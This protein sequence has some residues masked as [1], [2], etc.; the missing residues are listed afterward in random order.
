[1]KGR[2]KVR[3]PF[4]ILL[5]ILS[6]PVFAQPTWTLDPFG[7][8]KKPEKYEEKKLGSEKTA[9]K[10]FTTF[11]RLVQN[12]VTHYNFYF[13][14]N[15]KLNAVL[16]RAK[17]AQ[18]DDF[19]QLITFY[20]YSLDNTASQAVELDS[21][22]Y[23]ST[24]GILLH[25]LRSDWVDNMYL[26]IGKAYYFRKQFDSAALTF[27]FINYNLFPR[28]KNEDDNR[29]VGGNN[30]D[31]GSNVLSIANR[32]KRNVVQR[33]LTLPPSRNDAL[34]WLARTF[35]E[36]EQFGDAAGMINILQSDPNLPKRL[37]ND[38]DEVTAYWFFKQKTYDS[39][40]VYLERG[41]SNADNKTDKARWQYLLGQLFE[42]SGQYDKA[43]DYYSKAAKHTVDPVMDIY[44]HL[45]DA[46]MMRNA[47]NDKELDNSIS[48]LLK[49]AKKDKYESYR[50]II[51]HSAGMLS[52]KKPDT[53]S[54]ITLF[55]KSLKYNENNAAF[56]NKAHLELGKIAYNQRQYKSAA[57]HYDSLDLAEPALAFDS[58]SIA[59]RKSTL[60][61]IAQELAVI[62]KQ[63][64]VQMIAAMPGPER[65]A[66]IRKLAKK[67]RKESG[68]KEDSDFEGNTLITAFDNKKTDEPADLFQSSSKGE[69]YFYNAGMKSKGFNEFKA[70]WGKREN[71]DNW[72]R[73]SAMDPGKNLNS[74]VDDPLAPD[75]KTEDAAT[76][77]PVAYSY[78][79][80]MAD[81]PL[82]PEQLDSSNAMIADAL[83]KLA[84]LFEYEL[85]DYLEAVYTYDIYLQRFPDRLKDG[86]IY[87]GLYHCYT[88][89]GDNNKA[90]YYKNLLDTKFANSSYAN[91]I[92]NP[93]V[94]QPEKNNPV[95]AARYEAIYNKF[96]EGDFA[97]A[98]EEKRVADSIHGNHYWTPQLLYIEAVHYIKE[99]QDSLAIAV[100]TNIITLY[101]ESS[102]KPKAETMIE[103]LKRR[104]EIEAYLTNLEVTRL[105]EDDKIIF[106][107]DKA[108]QT[109]TPVVKAPTVKKM[110]PVRTL[111]APKD[112]AVQL[113]PS[114]VMGVY[115]WQASKP[116]HVIMVLDRVDGVYINEAKNA[117]TRYNREKYFSKVVINKDAIDAQRSL[118]V[119]TSF[120][121][122][123]EA[124]AYFDKVK[125]AAPQEVSWLQ[126]SKYSFLVISEENLQLLKTN[127]DINT[128][129]TL[130][131]NQY[132]GKF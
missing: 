116:H 43:S 4:F 56:K 35:T 22:I 87:L 128:Y 18:K 78:D 122:A 100:L 23:K 58:A 48:T 40:A 124:V 2:M 75:Q 25:D 26:L 126:A 65:D 107:D 7:K 30:S 46:K 106:A 15:N 66:F 129:K 119:F 63:D 62:E 10:K 39:A 6:T 57:D 9:D 94:L 108:A 42:M 14:A 95:T 17:I 112:S 81:I 36:T 96:I 60:R 55:E 83:V 86:E 84:K 13:N 67:F 123:D 80:L 71:K 27:Q 20:P 68:M 28:K 127:K 125:K 93:A 79:A 99:R 97:A 61:K 59:D 118:L 72:R 73:K 1:M 53:T 76:G 12:N 19:S 45:N 110:E 89:L 54:G 109:V 34:I 130:L 111:P 31:G 98:I 77:K 132:P 101:P 16:E 120:E 49:M 50:D 92:N 37:K 29:I 115:K 33:V 8:E 131:N 24:G 74:N 47:G 52:L 3:F 117:F 41:I 105:P 70:K 51:Y 114:M 85:Q 88:K 11:R 21:V 113:P 104:G 91:M 5:C 102:L 82:T 32:E 69:W 90:A 44:A 121:N 64:S 38:L 103:V